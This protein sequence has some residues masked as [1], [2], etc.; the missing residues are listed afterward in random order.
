MSVNPNNDLKLSHLNVCQHNVRGLLSC[1]KLQVINFLEEHDIH[2]YLA[3]EIWLKPD[4]V[5]FLKNYT[6]IDN[7]RNDGYAGAAILF[8]NN[9]T[10]KKYDLPELELINATAATTVN[11]QKNIT[12]ISV[13]VPA[14]KKNLNE[15]LI[16]QDLLKLTD[17]NAF[18]NAWGSEYNDVRGILLTDE[19]ETLYHE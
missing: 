10:F 1:N 7:R 17:S 2:I 11:L 5:F 4:E 6:I 8:K 19:L 15:S 14:K 13:Y 16:R 3:S 18:H 12:F 9:I